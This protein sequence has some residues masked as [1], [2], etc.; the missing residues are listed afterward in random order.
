MLEMNPIKVPVFKLLV[1][2]FFCVNL[3]SHFRPLLRKPHLYI[4]PKKKNFFQVH[5][6]YLRYAIS[7]ELCFKDEENFVLFGIRW[8]TFENLDA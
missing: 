1:L 5:A 8:T 3:S 2:Q 6:E 4:I 7:N